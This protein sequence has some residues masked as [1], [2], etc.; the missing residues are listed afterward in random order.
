[1]T[2]DGFFASAPSQLDV[3][4]TNPPFG[5]KEGQAQTLFAYKTSAMQV[6]FLQHVVDSLKPGGRCG[7]II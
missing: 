3:V 5:A 2:Y 7:M 1:M 4:L 6:L